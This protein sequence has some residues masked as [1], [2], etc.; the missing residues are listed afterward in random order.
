MLL[1]LNIFHTYFSFPKEFSSLLSMDLTV[2]SLISMCL[3][4]FVLFFSIDFNFNSVMVREYVCMT[5]IF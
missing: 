3:E 1:K 5:Q 4:I 2:F